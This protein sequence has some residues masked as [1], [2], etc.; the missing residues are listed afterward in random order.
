[1]ATEKETEIERLIVARFDRIDR[2]LEN[3]INEIKIEMVKVESRLGQEI[4]KLESRLGKEI[5]Q[6]ESKLGQEIARIKVDVNW[7]KWL[8]GG[9]LSA[10]LILL[11]IIITILFKLVNP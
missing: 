2:K 9:L 5:V 11:S 1:M 10:I 3:Q 7:I 4:N 6:V 8:F